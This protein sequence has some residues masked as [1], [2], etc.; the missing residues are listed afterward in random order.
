[1]KVHSISCFNMTLFFDIW[2]VILFRIDLSE[3]YQ[4]GDKAGHDLLNDQTAGRKITRNQKRKHDEINHVQKV[5]IDIASNNIRN[6]DGVILLNPQH[7][8]CEI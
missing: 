8:K 4:R 1:M 5:C 6:Q 2:V 7:F 3:L